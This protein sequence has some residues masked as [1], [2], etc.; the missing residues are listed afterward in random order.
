M[1]EA[2][3]KSHAVYHSRSKIGMVI[4][5]RESLVQSDY[6]KVSPKCA[7]L[8]ARSIERDDI[9]ITS[10]YVRTQYFR[11]Q[12]VWEENGDL[13]TTGFS[14]IDFGGYFPAVLMN[15][16]LSKMISQG[17]V[18]NYKKLKSIDD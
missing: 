11:A 12:K 8:F 14:S 7:Y 1:D 10:E 17:K 16:I 5:A 9:P 4:S 3:D 2:E 13:Y 18:K 15:M 6:V